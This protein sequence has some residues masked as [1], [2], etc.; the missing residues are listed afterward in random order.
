MIKFFLSFFTAIFFTTGL[1]A[2]TSNDSTKKDSPVETKL[3]P[4]RDSTNNTKD[5]TI[6]KP[7]SS[8]FP[9]KGSEFPDEIV[10]F[11][12]V[13]SMN[14]YFNF[15]GKRQVQLSQEHNSSSTDYLFYLLVSILLYFGLIRVFFEKYMNNLFQLFF[16]ISMRQQQIREQLLQTPLPSLLLN[17]LFVISGGLYGCFLI[18]YYRMTDQFN[19]PSLL[20]YCC[21]S[22]FLLYL[23]KFA[24]LK[25]CGWIF[26]IKKAADAY[27]FVVFLINKMLG[28][29]L[30]PFLIIMAFA[31]NNDV[32]QIIITIS[33]ILLIILFIY[34]FSAG[35]RQVRTEIKISIFHF[36]IY[37]CAFEITPLIL[38]YKLFLSN[39]EKAF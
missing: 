16:R 22:L 3:A 6:I 13:L 29:L 15:L 18:E 25:C 38:I 31:N 28:I 39:L 32:D 24:L 1:V 10:L 34:R 37:L 21:G 19:F 23:V 20:A 4:I 9:N 27:I 30:I 33:F 11:K 36:F 35:Y 14:A 5:S 8:T 2:Q 17:V 26:N 12:K 7:D